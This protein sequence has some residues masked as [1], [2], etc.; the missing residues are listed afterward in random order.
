MNSLNLDA[1]NFH[2]P[3]LVGF[4]GKAFIFTTDNVR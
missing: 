2:A 4:D 3:Y 1:I